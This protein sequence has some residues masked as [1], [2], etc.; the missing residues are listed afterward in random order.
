MILIN[1]AKFTGKNL[2]WSL[3]FNKVAGWI[4][5]IIFSVH[6]HSDTL[7]R[8]L[9]MSSLFIHSRN[10][11]LTSYYNTTIKRKCVTIYKLKVLLLCFLLF[12][13]LSKVNTHKSRFENLKEVKIRA[14]LCLHSIRPMELVEKTELLRRLSKIHLDRYGSF[15]KIFLSLSWDGNLNTGVVHIIQNENLLHVLP[16]HD[17]SFSGD[18]FYYDLNSLSENVSWND[19]GV[20]K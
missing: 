14:F 11:T 4:I 7:Y 15:R 13:F 16:F 12:R 19:W 5:W 8:I 2:C 3:I 6:C 10:R 9:R 18:G 1:F 20:F 17:C